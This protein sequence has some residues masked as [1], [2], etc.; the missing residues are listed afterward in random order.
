MPSLTTV[1]VLANLNAA[2]SADAHATSVL[3]ANMLPDPSVLFA[4]NP[5]APVVFAEAYV[6]VICL[7]K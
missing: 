7:S 2:V 6:F 4:V 1:A 3:D 5:I